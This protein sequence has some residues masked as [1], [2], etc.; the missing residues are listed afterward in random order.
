MVDSVN[1]VKQRFKILWQPRSIFWRVLFILICT[2]LLSQIFAMLLLNITQRQMIAGY[3]LQQT[4]EVLAD[5]EQQ[6]ETLPPQQQEIFLLH[7]NQPFRLQLKSPNDPLVP[8]ATNQPTQQ[9][10]LSILKRL[11]HMFGGNLEARIRYIPHYQLWLKISM[12]DKPY[13][14]VIPLGRYQHYSY[15]ALGYL[16]ATF[17]VLAIFAAGLFAWRINLPLRRLSRAVQKLGRGVSPDPLPI[18]GPYEV[19]MLAQTFN[20][21]LHDLTLTERERA[22][23]L[24]GLSHDLR[25]PITRLRLCVEMMQDESLRDGMIQDLDDMERIIQQFIDYVRSESEEA[26]TDISLNA[27]ILSVCDRYERNNVTVMTD[28]ADKLPLQKLKPIATARVLSNLLDNAIRYAKPPFSISTK[29]EGDEIVLKVKDCGSGIPAHLK[30]E[31]IKPFFRLDP[32]RRANGGSG[33][34]LSIVERTAKQHQAKLHLYNH[35][36]GGLIVEIRYPLK[37]SQVK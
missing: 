25:T 24:A 22:T 31:I 7:W 3:V 34:G 26:E 28:L 16:A 8:I 12:L 35:L 18:Q 37:V 14:L 13:W 4:V 11:E 1:K 33:L 29:K 17:I 21:M 10:E 20:Q 6:M 2:L 30:D 36:K 32:A 9:L 23:M 27:I 19:Q 15:S 5:L